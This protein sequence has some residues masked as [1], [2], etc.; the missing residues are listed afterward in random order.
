MRWVFVN[1]RYAPFLGGSEQHVQVLAEHLARRG[2]EVG[3]V[4]SNAFDLEYFW[5]GSTR[6][7]RRPEVEQVNEVTVRRV[8]VAH[9]WNRPLTFQGGRRGMGE[10][11][12]WLSWEWP[13]REVSRR[14]PR[15]P[16]LEAAMLA[17]GTPDIVFA[18]NLG[19]EGLALRAHDV[20]REHGA[21]FALMPLLHLGAKDDPVPRRYVSMPHQRRLLRDA[22]LVFAMTEMEAEFISGLGVSQSRIAV[23]GVGVFP[24]KLVGGDGARFRRDHQLEG[25]VVGALG[26]LAP[27]KGTLDLV[28]AVGY[29]RARRVAMSLVAAGPE[30]ST[31]SREIARLPAEVCEGIHLL[32]VI[33][34]AQKR[35][36]LAAIDVLALP[37]RSESFGIVF[38][39]AWANKK[40]VIGANAG[41]VPEL[42]RTGENGL[43][44][45]FGRPE[46][47]GEALMRLKR[48]PPEAVTLGEAG[49]RLMREKY[50]WPRVL[51]RMDEAYERVLGI[52]VTGCA[53]RES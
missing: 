48:N 20:A 41:A 27:E 28:R 31:F 5:D 53:Q 4:T 46:A 15:L 29:A 33:T 30:L 11:S 9:G 25:F 45:A 1:H 36:M 50:T 42:V 49:E 38:L 26:A 16:D 51:A 13:F 34:Q 3:V 37:S 47:L 10:A 7:V 43:L 40:P 52:D 24:D 18:T 19:L 35:D 2:H 21:A 44:V 22:D 6:R 14:F 39:E 23:V 12:R 8:P 32:G 17:D